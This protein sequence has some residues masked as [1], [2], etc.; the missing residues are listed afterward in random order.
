MGYA[1]SRFP[2]YSTLK[3]DHAGLS[4][5]S[6]MVNAQAWNIDDSEAPTIEVFDADAD[7]WKKSLQCAGEAIVFQD[8]V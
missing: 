8:W 4:H 2:S 1:L 3:Y 7:E 5:G 6:N